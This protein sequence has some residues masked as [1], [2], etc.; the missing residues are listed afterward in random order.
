[1]FSVIW[2]GSG[3][4]SKN[5]VSLSFPPLGTAAFPAAWKAVGLTS[6]V[7]A[8]LIAVSWEEHVSDKTLRPESLLYTAI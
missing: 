5:T 3:Q 6:R 1:M 7:P 4:I 8:H 2:V